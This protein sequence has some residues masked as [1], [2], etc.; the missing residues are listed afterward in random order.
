M[1]HSLYPLLSQCSILQQY[2]WCRLV[3]SRGLLKSLYVSAVPAIAN[4][5]PSE[6]WPGAQGMNELLP[7]REG[8]QR[9]A[10]GRDLHSCS[11]WVLNY[12]WCASL[13]VHSRAGR[14][15]LRASPLALNTGP[16]FQSWNK[17]GR[18]DWLLLRQS[19]EHVIL[20]RCWNSVDMFSAL[21][22]CAN[23]GSLP[24]RG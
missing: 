1:N 18:L 4:P 19:S 14:T 12:D 11:C 7:G 5:A 10:L 23:M 6:R 2:S 16:G 21:H 17:K 3:H 8:N 9:L 20:H 22:V 15:Q 13:A 24:P